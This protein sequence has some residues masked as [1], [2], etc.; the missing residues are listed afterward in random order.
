LVGTDGN[1]LVRAGGLERCTGAASA[2]AH[3]VINT[4]R[5]RTT[6]IAFTPVGIAQGISVDHVRTGG[7]GPKL[8]RL[9]DR[10][11]LRNHE[12]M[13]E[14]TRKRKITLG[15]ARRGRSR[16]FDLLL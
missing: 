7:L 2:E 3:K 1:T 15:D 10:S 8:W 16:S 12:P 13:P 6:R 9:H 5:A 14:L 4:P 11:N